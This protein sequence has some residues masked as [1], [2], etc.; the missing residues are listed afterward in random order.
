MEYAYTKKKNRRVSMDKRYLSFKTAVISAL[1]IIVCFA[2]TSL[3]LTDKTHMRMV[4]GDVAFPIIE[5][6]VISTLFYAAYNSKKQEKNLKIAWT[7]MA[8]AFL[9]Y[10]LGDITWA[11]LELGLNQTPFPSVADVFYLAFYPIFAMGIYLFPRNPYSRSDELKIILEMGIVILTVSLIF[12]MFLITPNI[13]GKGDLFTGLISVIY[14][15][16]DF[17]L[18]FALLRLLYGKF[19]EKYYYQ[20][21]L[22]GLG[23]IALIIAD[24]IYSYQELQGTYISGGLLDTVWII[25]FILVGLAGFLQFSDKYNSYYLDNLPSI[26]LSEFTSYLPIFWGILA[27]ILLVWTYDTQYFQEIW[28]IEIGVGLIILLVLI[29]QFITIYENKKLYKKAKKEINNRIEVE[30]ALSSSEKKYRELVNNSMVAIYQTNLDG[31][32]LFAN[33]AM[34][35]IFKFESVEELKKKKITEMYKNPAKREN[36][37]RI[38]KKEGNLDQCEVEMVSNTGETIFILLSSNLTNESI[39][40]MIMDITQRKHAEKAL[41]ENEEKY[42]SLFESDPDY[43]LLLD[44]NGIILDANKAAVKFTGLSKKELIGKH[45]KKLGISIKEYVDLKEKFFLTLKGQDVKPSVSILVNQKGENNWVESQFVPIKKNEDI[46]SVL[47][48]ATDI[49]KKKRATDQLKSS[50]EEKEILLK[51]IHHRVKNNMQIISSLLNLQTQYIDDDGAADI[52]KESQNRVKSMAMLH[53][54]LYQSKNFTHIKFEDYVKSLVSDLFF[55]YSTSLD[56]VRLTIEV[57]DLSLNLETAVPLGLIISELVS[58]CLK[59]AFP[60]GR[61]GEI[62]VSLKDHYGNYELIVSDDGIGLQQNLEFENTKSLG[63]QLVHNL[64]NQIDGEITIDSSHGTKFKIV[65]KEL[66]YKERL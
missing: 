5:L 52:L 45:L 43:T 58:N 4:F 9:S 63:L 36:I 57:D 65:F 38:L 60:H 29:R 40:G 42:R 21:I 19:P 66:K 50:V 48:I 62:H 27:F 35:K 44:M 61:K 16:A 32:I 24:S 14:I 11:V 55:T 17:I 6:L 49:T 46:S 7:L 53:E 12:W 20:L 39:S 15:I 56:Q 28:Q 22:I 33:D 25:G 41:Q 18:L 37:I 3:L 2:F 26:K 1:L 64:T 31:D 34:A 47:L 51:E 8:L 13:S 10:A 59:H 54:K 30:K 23:I